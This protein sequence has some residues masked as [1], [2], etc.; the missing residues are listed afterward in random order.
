MKSDE[1]QC[2]P[3][4]RRH[5]RLFNRQL[6]Q[7]DSKYRYRSST[8]ITSLLWGESNGKHWIPLTKGQRGGKRFYVMTSSLS[9]RHMQQL[10]QSEEPVINFTPDKPI[11]HTQ[12]KCQTKA[13]IITPTSFTLL[14]CLS[15]HVTLINVLTTCCLNC[16]NKAFIE[17]CF[18]KYWWNN[19]FP[20]LYRCLSVFISIVNDI[21]YDVVRMWQSKFTTHQCTANIIWTSPWMSTNITCR[22]GG[23]Y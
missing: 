18:R 2:A 1:R 12:Y 19:S 21:N 16:V 6:V 7:A 15:M 8:H 23:R 10:L 4:H 14:S 20:K 3:I 22:P 9:L 5:N 11:I 13:F 17:Q